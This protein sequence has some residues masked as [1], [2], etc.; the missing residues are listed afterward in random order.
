M[1]ELMRRR[2]AL[3]GVGGGNDYPEQEIGYNLL[4]DVQNFEMLNVGNPASSRDKRWAATADYIPINPAYT[5]K[6]GRTN[7]RYHVFY[8]DATKTYISNLRTDFG[9]GTVSNLPSGTAFVKVAWGYTDYT[10]SQFK[11]SIDSAGAYD[12]T[13]GSFF[14]R[15]T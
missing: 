12:Q 15:K 5:Y 6:V 4:V 9:G 8:Y 7:T 3:M 13:K 1:T 14:S 10:I 11:D 2:R